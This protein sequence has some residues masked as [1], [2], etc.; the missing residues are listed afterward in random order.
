M[1]VDEVLTLAVNPVPSE[2]FPLFAT[3]AGVDVLAQRA[4][5]EVNEVASHY[6]SIE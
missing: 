3:H 5:K 2:G 4:M 1:I 6:P